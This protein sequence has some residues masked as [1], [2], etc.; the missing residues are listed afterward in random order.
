MSK[1]LISASIPPD[2]CDLTA[3]TQNVSLETMKQVALDSTG[4]QT[5]ALEIT[6]LCVLVQPNLHPEKW[7]KIRSAQRQ[8]R[9]MTCCLPSSH[10]GTKMCWKPQN[11]IDNFRTA[12]TISFALAMNHIAFWKLQRLIKL[13]LRIAL[14]ASSHNNC[15]TK[16]AKIEQF[17]H[18][19]VASL[20]SILSTISSFVLAWSHFDLTQHSR[21]KLWVTSK[22]LCCMNVAIEAEYVLL[23]SDLFCLR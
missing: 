4:L 13:P 14:C 9:A 3:S 5:A 19:T 15:D 12:P 1:G 18:S 21:G 11:I 16:K 23:I 17:C 6:D 10:C 20:A 22:K 2:A 8:N 7:K